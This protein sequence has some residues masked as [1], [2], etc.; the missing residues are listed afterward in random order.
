MV[1][2]KPNVVVVYDRVAT[3]SGTS[4]VWQLASPT[5]P[6]ISGA[7]AQIAGTHQLAVQRLVPATAA[8]SV[9]NMTS[10]TGYLSGYRLDEKVAGGDQRYLHVLSLDGAVRSATATGDTGV[11]ISLSD[12]STAY[13]TFEHDAIGASLTWGAVSATLG[14]GV[15]DLP[16]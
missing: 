12:G 13:V 15:D 9:Y 16:Q 2:L 14:A 5:A 4:Q 1:F 10:T 7:T 8:S 11:T 3:G 6:A